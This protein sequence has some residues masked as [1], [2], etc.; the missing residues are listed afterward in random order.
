[1]SVVETVVGLYKAMSKSEKTDLMYELSALAVK[2]NLDGV[3]DRVTASTKV[4]HPPKKRGFGKSKKKYWVKSVTGFDA[5]E[6][7]VMQIAGT[8][9]DDV[10]KDT[11]DNSYYIVGFRQTK[12]Y[13]L[14]HVDGSGKS[15]VENDGVTVDINGSMIFEADNFKDLCARVEKLFA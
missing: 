10:F 4:S 14:C 11:P 6:K 1:M 12:H 9:V 13:M 3:A 8:W 15:V 7:G 5:K 2:D